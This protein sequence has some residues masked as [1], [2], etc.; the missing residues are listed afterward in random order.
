MNGCSEEMIKDGKCICSYYKD[1][2]C[3]HPS[4]TV[5]REDGQ[6]CCPYKFE[7]ISEAE[8]DKKQEKIE[9]EKHK[10]FWNS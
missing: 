8:W 6:P 1:G 2:K 3:I 10:A 9:E 7:A 5:S 4:F